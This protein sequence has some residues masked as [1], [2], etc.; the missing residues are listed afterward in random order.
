MKQL[1]ANNAKT[2]LVANI[3]ST[4]T[5]LQVVDASV[6][7]TPGA[8]EYFLVTLEVGTQIEIVRIVGKA[9]NN[10]YMAGVGGRAQEGTV[11]VAFPAASRVEARITRDTLNLF[12]KAFL[13][14]TSVTNLVA[15]SDSLNT[16]YICGS[17]DLYG[18]PAITVTK[19]GSTW[20]FLNYS[21]VQSGVSTTT[22]T[23]TLINTSSVNLV[24]VPSGKYLIQI[25]SGANSGY[26][27]EVTS[28]TS[29]T[30]SWASALPVAPADGATFE[31]VQSNA[32][33]LIDTL[34][35]GDDAVIMPLILGN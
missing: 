7:P 35:I 1:F 34:N 14:L 20:R 8:N 18:N 27:R 24:G 28:Y 16:G 3:S 11:A 9:G 10:L 31:L 13:P 29:T 22:N 4:D 30:I 15:P 23:T 32:S 6:F 21:T 5:S 17:L 2:T 12:S 33:I 26:V 25:T 19:D